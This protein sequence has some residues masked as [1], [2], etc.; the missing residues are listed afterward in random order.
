MKK[1][2]FLL[3]ATAGF[4]A[5]TN[6]SLV[7]ENS[8]QA[9][10][11][12]ELAIGFDTYTSSST[13]ATTR[14]TYDGNGPFSADDLKGTYSADNPTGGFG[15]FAYTHLGTLTTLG[16][17]YFMYNQQVTYDPSEG[18][19]A[20]KYTPI[21]Y[22]PNMTQG[23]SAGSGYT[24]YTDRW[25]GNTAYTD[26]KTQYVSFFA[27]APYVKTSDIETTA[28]GE[29]TTAYAV[30][31]IKNG[32]SGHKEYGV[33]NI[34][35]VEASGTTTITYKVNPNS[36]AAEDLLWG[37]APLG[38]ISYRAVSGD[39]I[40]RRAGLPLINMLKP[41]THTPMK[42]LFQHALTAMSMDIQLAVDQVDA[43]TP[44][45]PTTPDFG[46]GKTKVFV[47]SIALVPKDKTKFGF[48]TT[49][50]LNL[51]NES[52][53]VP[54]WEDT[55]IS[56]TSGGTNPGLLVNAISS[57]EGA[58]NV[59]LP[60]ALTNTADQPGV[61]AQSATMVF[62]SYGSD[63]TID[64]DDTPLIFIPVFNTVTNQT[65]TITI[66]YEVVTTDASNTAN[67]STVE[68]T[69]SKDVVLKGFRPGRYYK[70]HLLLGLTS[71]K[72]DAD[73]LDWAVEEQV[74]DLP[75][76]LD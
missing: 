46:D 10:E 4:I 11:T 72:I 35:T 19:N 69:I 24:A 53:N 38:G 25:T 75:R 5:C 21:K 50:K 70:L 3:M 61:K 6:D 44:E 37:T 74:V 18:V 28:G 15:I 27:Y 45:S 40:N 22:W 59:T 14:S 36:S 64:T 8:D 58:G 32:D 17:S 26:N 47:K 9:T 42:F 13:K 54:K 43:S 71:V 52:P 73:A 39:Y 67:S 41:S 48:A 30:G 51:N 66:V 16:A 49:G 29:G 56:L 1:Y 34:S 7:P 2:Y 65:L 60:T 68:N 63:A 20:W 23:T 55:G 76:N 62:G 31:D 12:E 33:T 57:G